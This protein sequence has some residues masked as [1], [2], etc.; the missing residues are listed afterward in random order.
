MNEFFTTALGPTLGGMVAPVLALAIVLL[1]IIL[2]LYLGKQIMGSRLIGGSKGRAKRLQVMD[3][4]PIDG[5]RRVLLVRRDDVEHLVMIG[6]PNDLVIEPSIVRNIPSQPLRPAPTPMP[7]VDAPNE[8][9][10]AQPTMA[11]PAAVS[12]PSPTPSATPSVAPSAT[13][14]PTVTPPANST[15]PSF[16][17]GAAT[18]TAAG[19]GVA[20]AGSGLLSSAGKTASSATATI[21]SKA[22]DVGTAVKD[23]LSD[24]ISQIAEKLAP[25]TQSVEPSVEAPEV[26]VPSVDVP[27]VEAETSA[28]ID[29]PTSEPEIDLELE[30]NFQATAFPPLVSDNGDDEDDLDMDD[31]ERS[32]VEDLQVETADLGDASKDT[33]N[34]TPAVSNDTLMSELEAEMEDVLNGLSGDKQ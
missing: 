2:M 32:L 9:L 5:R 1:L 15:R 22:T 17:S 3:A 20:A 7:A 19:A 28:A 27:E 34:E 14:S 29:T 18:L 10:V 6:G 26:E 8:S 4:T 13:A 23:E 24:T 12:A 30:D 31:L 33:P 25:D 11:P 21:G 16:S